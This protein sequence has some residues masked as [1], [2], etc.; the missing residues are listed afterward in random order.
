[1][2]LLLFIILLLRGGIPLGILLLRGLLIKLLL[3][4]LLL[5]LL[6]LLGLLDFIFF[7]V[8]LFLTMLN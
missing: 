1:M 6:G 4:L 5:V 8:E 2:L 3:G 7:S